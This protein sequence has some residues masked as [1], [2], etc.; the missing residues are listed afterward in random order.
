MRTAEFKA[1]VDSFR[2]EVNSQLAYLS[3]EL[4][5][6]NTMHFCA[7]GFVRNTNTGNLAY[8]S[9][10]DVRFFFDQWYNHVLYRTAKH[11]KDYSGGMNQYCSLPNL[12]ENLLRITS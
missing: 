11:E 2:K 10:S 1:F 3:L 8:F 7:S 5:G 12:G 9:I 6:F 4:V